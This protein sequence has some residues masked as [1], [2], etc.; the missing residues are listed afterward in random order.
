[1]KNAV[2]KLNFKWKKQITKTKNATIVTPKTDLFFRT[3]NLVDFQNSKYF[4]TV[5]PKTLPE[6]IATSKNE[7]EEMFNDSST[8][9]TNEKIAKATCKLLL[10]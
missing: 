9:F 5:Y 4:K 10:M 3:E 2:W 6:K 1:L 8:T 7:F